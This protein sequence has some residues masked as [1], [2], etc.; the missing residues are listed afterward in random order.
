MK[1]EIQAI[2]AIKVIVISVVS[3]T[4]NSSTGSLQILKFTLEL[5]RQLQGKQ[6]N[7][8]LIIIFSRGK[9]LLQRV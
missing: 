6:R 1:G 9:E 3:T 7:T 5:N 2:S 8:V 4:F